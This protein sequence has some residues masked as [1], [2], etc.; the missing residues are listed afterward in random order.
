MA[1]LPEGL[2]GQVP[3]I[4]VSYD[5]EPFSG[6]QGSYCW[7][8]IATTVQTASTSALTCYA[9]AL[10]DTSAG[11]PTIAVYPNATLS[12]QFPDQQYPQSLTASLYRSG[13]MQPVQSNVSAA[14][15]LALGLLPAG[16]Y[17]LSVH[18]TYGQS[19]T[20]EYF[21][22]QQIE[23]ANFHAGSI[24]IAIAGP[25]VQMEAFSQKDPSGGTSGTSFPGLETWPLT[26]SSATVQRDVNLSSISV[27]DGNWVRFIPSVVPEVGPNGTVVDMLL[28]G[29]VRPFV[30]ND[31][32]N[33]SMIIQATTGDGAFGEAALPL[34]G[35]AGP[36][37]IHSL[38][39]PSQQ[40]EGPSWTVFAA[41]QTN[42]GIYSMVY[43]PASGDSS[44]SL[45]VSASIV[46]FFNASGETGPQPSWLQF[47]MPQSS[48]NLSMTAYNPLYFEIG[49]TSTSAAPLG[50]Y[51]LVVDVNVGGQ[52]VTIY[53][54]VVVSPPIFG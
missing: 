19:F 3:R 4:E 27:I 24:Q 43:D 20:S 36:I 52:V 9:A 30:D 18:A 2:V 46:G 26:L 45:P 5:N 1:P 34:E 50:T 47:F 7:R 51:T 10:P 16:G 23:S 44:Q 29:A 37:V 21:G 38:S 22:I 15:E 6:F 40:S 48:T 53:T 35:S 42:F 8:G 49:Y 54:P 25:N 41:N 13:S 31:I 28:A 11:L 39:P 33:V 12:F 14:S 17:I 32:S